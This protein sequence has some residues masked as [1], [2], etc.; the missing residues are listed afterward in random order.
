MSLFLGVDGGGTKT[1]FLLLDEFGR[2]LATHHESGSYYIQV[3]IEGVR[4][5]VIDGTRAVVSR[6]GRQPRDLDFAFFGLPAHGEDRVNTLQ[7]DQLP[8]EL[9]SAERY[10]CG[11][12]MICGWAGSLAC[13]DGINV[14]AGTGSICY[15]EY[16]HRMARCGGWGELFSDEGS[17]YWIAREGLTVF[18][19]MSDHRTAR[20]P[21]YDL[22]MARFGLANDIE[23]CG[24]IYDR[25]AQQ[26]DRIAALSILVRQAAEAGDTAALDIFTRAGHALAELADTTRRT[27][28][29]PDS[30]TV[31]VS[32]SGGL[33]RS[34]VLLLTPFMSS[35]R[36]RYGA[37]A[38]QAPR[39]GPA[40]GAALY[41]AYCNGAPLSDQA[42]EA[43]DSRRDLDH[44][45]TE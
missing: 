35:L 19:R 13:R 28:G 30:E 34:G 8:R 16:R 2:I 12:D 6:I 29:F 20:G 10:R 1:A 40:T 24:K 27:L 7:L 14:V 23:L 31:P 9:L 26:R 42:L 41:A 38:P 32:Y 21:L 4:R 45:H 18:S 39:F 36:A 15:G 5:V 44:L 11:N 25:E 3:G 37:F 33:F 43:L 22:V 17:A